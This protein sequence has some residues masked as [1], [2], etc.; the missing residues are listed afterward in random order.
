MQIQFTLFDKNEKYRPIS[1]LIEIE[2]LK[3]YENN[4]SKYTSKAL[5]KI[6]AQKQMTKDELMKQGYTQF[7]TRIYNKKEIERQNKIKYLQKIY[8]NRKKKGE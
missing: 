6:M 4:K 1:T 5:Q 8:E 3:D 7:K 2:S